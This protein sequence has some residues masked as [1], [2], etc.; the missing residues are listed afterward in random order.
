MDN[1]IFSI[2]IEI[3]GLE[4]LALALE[5]LAR[6]GHTQEPVQPALQTTPVQ[7]AVQTA[8]VQQ[9][10]PT[11]PAQQ[12]VQTAP[13]Q[14]AV[15]TAPAQQAVATSMAQYTLDDLARAAMTLMDK[16][17][18]S[19]LQSLLAEFGVELLPL[20]PA[21]HYGAFATRLRG[22]GAQI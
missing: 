4:V 1:T 7:Q 5:K 20:L 3:P 17:M 9:P 12:P 10:V 6:G 18:Q 13:V 14:Q 19:Q 2:K 15:Q 8:P 11:T 22:M 21:S 16:G